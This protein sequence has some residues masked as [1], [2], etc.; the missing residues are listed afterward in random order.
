[1]KVKQ[2]KVYVR[3]QGM[4]YHTNRDCPMLADGDFESMRYKEISLAEAKQQ[5]FC[6]CACVKKES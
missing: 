3:P 4:H 1:M 5:E 2:I 6:S